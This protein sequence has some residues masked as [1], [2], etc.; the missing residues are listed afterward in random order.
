[1][2]TL[3]GYEATRQIRALESAQTRPKILALTASA[4]E[5]QRAS[6]LAAG[7]DDFLAKPFRE[8]HLFEKLAEHLGVN[9]LYEEDNEHPIEDASHELTLTRSMLATMPQDWIAEL[10]QASLAVDADRILQ[11]VQRTSDANLATALTEL[12]YKFCFDE[13]AELSQEAQ[14]G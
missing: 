9:Y 6:V 5:E 12:V 3:N 11:L 10:H 8:S 14:E 4:F 1:M 13:I 2:P 7:C